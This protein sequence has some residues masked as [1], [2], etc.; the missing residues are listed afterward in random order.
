MRSSYTIK[1]KE[2]IIEP[3]DTNDIWE[4]QWNI[5]LLTEEKPV[6]IGTATF[7]GEK[8]LGAIPVRVELEPDY[9]NKKYGTEIFKL[10]VDFAFGFGNIYEVKAETEVEND[11]CRYALEKAGFVPTGGKGEEGLLFVR[12]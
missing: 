12:R 3:V 10:L 6:Q 1:T 4:G 8:M 11:K 7:A 5:T 2:F 9:R